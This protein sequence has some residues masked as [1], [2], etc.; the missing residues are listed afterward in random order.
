MEGIGHPGM[1]MP[2]SVEKFVY[3]IVQQAS[4]NPNRNPVQELD[5]VLEPIWAQGSLTTTD[6]LDLVLPFDEAIL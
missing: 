6:S 3:S 5:P 1:A 2:L 4:S